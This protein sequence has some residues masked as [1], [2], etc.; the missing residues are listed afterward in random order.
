MVSWPSTGS[1]RRRRRI[2]H[3]PS[4][5]PPSHTQTLPNSEAESPE[6][7][8]NLNVG[9]FSDAISARSFKGRLGSQEQKNCVIRGD[10]AVKNKKIVFEVVFEFN[11][12]FHFLC[13]IHL[14]RL[15]AVKKKN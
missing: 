9:V 6:S 7:H 2:F 8:N 10:W 1:R 12:I 15:I 14:K 5:L 4:F 11:V 13:T 3:L